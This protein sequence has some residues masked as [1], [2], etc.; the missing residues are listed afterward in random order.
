MT[1]P[2]F[3]NEKKHQH[4]TNVIFDTPKKTFNYYLKYNTLFF[5]PLRT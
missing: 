3:N 1:Q 5:V 4:T 2:L